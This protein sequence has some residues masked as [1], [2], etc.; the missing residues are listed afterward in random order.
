MSFCVPLCGFCGIEHGR[1]AQPV[2][3]LFRIRRLKAQMPVYLHGI[4]GGIDGKFLSGIVLPH[5]LKELR[6]ISACTLIL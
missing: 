6:L 3:D 5:S 4:G 2:G 1:I